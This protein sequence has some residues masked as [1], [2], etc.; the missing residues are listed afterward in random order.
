VLSPKELA[1]TNGAQA[2]ANGSAAGVTT[3]LTKSAD[4]V[5]RPEEPNTE[6]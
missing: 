6:G 4:A 2:S 1:L 5:E 3:S